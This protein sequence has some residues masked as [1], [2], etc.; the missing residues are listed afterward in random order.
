M[1]GDVGSWWQVWVN[2]IKT[3]GG[4]WSRHAASRW[5]APMSRLGPCKSGEA[6][7]CSTAE[8][9]GSVMCFTPGAG[10]RLVVPLTFMTGQ[11][12]NSAHR[13]VRAG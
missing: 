1:S 7:W 12:N 11:A 13:G 2:H 8:G 4:H 6:G 5:E 10:V 9:G 3:M